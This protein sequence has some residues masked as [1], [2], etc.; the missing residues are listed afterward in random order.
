MAPHSQRAAAVARL[1]VRPRGVLRAGRL[2]GR[3]HARRAICA[4]DG[5]ADPPLPRSPDMT[6][7][8][9]W[10]VGVAAAF[11]VY[12]YI[13]YPVAL[14]VLAI[15]RRRRS[16]DAGPGAGPG[17]GAG[18]GAGAG[19]GE[20]EKRAPAD[21]PRI[22]MVLPVYNEAAVIGDTLENLLKVDYPADRREILVLS[23]AST[24]ET[25][26]VVRGYAHRGVRLM[27]IPVRGGKTAAENAALPFLRGEIIVNTD[28][29]VRVHREAVKRLIAA[30]ADPTVGVASSYNVSV[31]RMTAH[32]N[33]A[34]GWYVGY[35]MWVRDLE[36][37]VSG[38][39][40]ATGCLYAVR[41]PIHSQRL[42]T[43]LTR[44]FAAAL[45][46][47]ERGLRA[48]S[49]RGAICFVPRIGSLQ[50]EYRRKVRTITGGIETLYFKRGLLNP[51]RYGL[52]A[53]ILASHKVCRWLMPHVGL[54]TLLAL[55]GLAGTAPWGL[56]GWGWP[57]RWQLP[58]ILAVPAYL[59]MGNLAA[60]HASIRA[61]RG[62]SV[63][64]WE[65]TRR[66]LT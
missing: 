45:L 30:F 41:A 55:A 66:P 61:F 22:T 8:A 38:S 40:G 62:A 46:A 16:G 23:D 7:V 11:A 65:P 26:A 3:A 9:L 31:A 28:A 56:V 29:S 60:L 32:A 37:R 49:V 44:D 10:V 48:V 13:G 17:A 25:D 36:S 20:A 19:E 51:F 4:R 33:A 14:F 52:F 24:D 58:R 2:Q 15:F 64:I 34:E 43:A 42:P 47:R 50:R 1:R 35:D 57:E 59:V 27:R 53:W 39:V 12:T 54:L 18:A 6:T 21:W 5:R 63:P